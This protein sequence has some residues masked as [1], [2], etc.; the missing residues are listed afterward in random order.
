MQ[1]HFLHAFPPQEG[2][3]RFEKCSH[4]IELYVPAM[5]ALQTKNSSALDKGRR[6]ELKSEELFVCK[7]M[8]IEISRCD[9][10][11]MGFSFHTTSF[12]EPD[13]QSAQGLVGWLTFVHV[14]G[15]ILGL[16]P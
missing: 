2:L 1:L 12:S 15:L 8:A 11:K 14:L 9:L 3:F 5:F 16:G 6:P 4:W 7:A 13:P 10:V